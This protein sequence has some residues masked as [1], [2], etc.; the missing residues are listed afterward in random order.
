MI[1]QFFHLSQDV[2]FSVKVRAARRCSN[3]W[4]HSALQIKRSPFGTTCDR[5]GRRN[6]ETVSSF[7]ASPVYP[8][9]A[10]DANSQKES[11][12]DSWQVVKRFDDPTKCETTSSSIN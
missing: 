9:E 4:T 2:S 6:V 12:V 5:V 11:Q 1:S 7:L 3:G 10:G 8:V